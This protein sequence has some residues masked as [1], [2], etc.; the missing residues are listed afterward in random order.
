VADADGA[1]DAAGAGASGAAAAAPLLEEGELGV[2]AEQ[3]ESSS[4]APE[5]SAAQESAVVRIGPRKR[6][7]GLVFMPLGRAP[8]TAGSAPNATVR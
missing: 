4:A 8:L 1:P 5:N 3:P 7:G 2:L 6:T